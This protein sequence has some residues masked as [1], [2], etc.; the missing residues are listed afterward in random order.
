MAQ[1]AAEE[2]SD[3]LRRGSTFGKASADLTSLPNLFAFTVGVAR[4]R[5]VGLL[6]KL[7]GG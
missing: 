6:G 1:L 2:V 7:L 3:V 4:A 5:C